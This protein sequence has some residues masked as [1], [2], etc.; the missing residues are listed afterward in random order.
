MIVLLILGGLQKFW[1][2]QMRT[3]DRKSLERTTT[4]DKIQ[5]RLSLNSP[6]LKKNF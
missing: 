2:Q 6:Q 4:V 1:Q 5:F 3:N